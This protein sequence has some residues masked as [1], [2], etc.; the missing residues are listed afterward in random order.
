MADEERYIMTDNDHVNNANI[1]R[2]ELHF[3]NAHDHVNHIG[4]GLNQD[5]DGVQIT[6]TK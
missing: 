4:R 6:I 3:D 5:A 1:E 2:R